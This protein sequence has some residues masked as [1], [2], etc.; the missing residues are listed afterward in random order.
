[1]NSLRPLKIMMNAIH[2]EQPLEKNNEKDDSE[3]T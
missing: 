2:F 3:V 1:M